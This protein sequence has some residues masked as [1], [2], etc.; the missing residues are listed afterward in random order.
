MLLTVK[1]NKVKN[2]ARIHVPGELVVVLGQE[3]R[4]AQFWIPCSFPYTRCPQN[5]GMQDKRGPGRSVCTVLQ[6]VQGT[7]GRY[8]ATKNLVLEFYRAGQGGRRGFGST[9][10]DTC[11]EEV[12]MCT[13]ARQRALI[14]KCIQVLMRLPCE[15]HSTPTVDGVTFPFVE[16]VS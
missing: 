2:H 12:R 16:N 6:C 9:D 4:S 13:L 8:E 3:S 1:L 7:T 14:C 11:V 10:T 5:L 15:I